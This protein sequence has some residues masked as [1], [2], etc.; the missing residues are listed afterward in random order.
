MNGVFLYPL[1]ATGLIIITI[2]I[3]YYL[4]TDT[5]RYQRKIYFFALAT[6]FLA[7]IIHS[8][9]KMLEGRSGDTIHTL[10]IIVF[11]FFIFF[12]QCSYYFIVVFIDYLINKNNTRTNKLIFIVLGF[13]AVNTIILAINYFYGFYFTVTK[14]NYF[15]YSSLF[16]VRFYISYSAILIAIVDIFLSKR[17]LHSLQI[18][19]IVFFA[20]LIGAGALLDILL[21]GGYFIWAF[22]TT[23]MLVAY[24]F[25]MHNDTMQDAVTGIGNRSSFVEF[26]N[27]ITKTN[28]R[29]SYIVALFDI[30]DLKKIN[31]NHGTSVGDSALAELAML[32]KKC[33]RQYD[34]VARIDADEFIVA[35][36]AEYDMKRLMARI[37]HSLQEHN[38]RPDRLFTLS[39]SY[40]Y[41]TFVANGNQTMDEFMRHLHE[42]VFLHRKEQHG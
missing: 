18:Y 15:M 2:L 29:Q 38:E 41:D 25:I 35:I 17:K 32:L 8:I 16:L 13:I 12:Q 39:V 11:N 24:F 3:S 23:A 42:L 27:R 22:L 19:L 4:R 31:S 33:S 7:I 40:G 5:D 20:V 21:P 34:F 36:N 10:L 30:N 26:V 6:V 1:F 14:D 28:T 37:L 9:G